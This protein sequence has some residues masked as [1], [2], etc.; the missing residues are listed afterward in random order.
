MYKL[1]LNMI[2]KNE[3]SIIAHTL[4][5]V[6][7][8]IPQIDYYVISDTGSTDDTV[9]VIKSFFKK[10][11]IKGEIYIDEWKDFGHNRS[12]ALE[13]AFKKSHYLIVFD[14]DDEI[15]GT[16]PVLDYQRLEFDGYLLTFGPHVRYERMLII[17]N[18]YRWCYKG[19]LHEYIVCEDKPDLKQ[20]SVQGDYYIVSGKHGHRSQ[21]PHKYKKDAILLEKA[22]EEAKSKND[23]LYNRY[24]FYCAQSYFDANDK[25]S[26]IQWYKKVCTHDGWIQEKYYA[27]YRLYHCLRE[28]RREEEG[29][30]YLIKS[31]MYD[32]QRYDCLYELIRYY[33]GNGMESIAWTFYRA[34]QEEFE[35]GHEM[36]PAQKL[37]V[38]GWY[39]K[40]GLPYY[41]IIVSVNTHHY[42]TAIKMF[43]LIFSKK[44]PEHNDFY[45][46]HLLM[47]VNC[48]LSHFPSVEQKDAFLSKLREYI[49]FLESIQYPIEKHESIYKNYLEIK[50]SRPT[51]IYTKEECF[52]STHILIYVGNSYH[53]W[54]Y[55]TYIETGTGG[56]ETA[57]IL[58]ALHFPKSYQVCIVGNVKEET[59]QNITFRHHDHASDWIQST[60][61]KLIIV[62]R[63]LQFF[64]RFRYSTFYVVAWAH[65]TCFHDDHLLAHYH[66]S[67]DTFVML[68]TWHQKHLQGRYPNEISESKC[69]IIFNGITLQPKIKMMS[70]KVKDRFIYSSCMERGLKKIIELWPAILEWKPNAQLIICTYQHNIDHSIIEQIKSY[71]SS[72]FFKG[73]MN[74][75]QLYQLMETCEYWFYPSHWPETS[76]ITAMEMMA[77]GILCCYYPYAGLADTIA[78]DCG[79]PLEEGKE[80][81]MMMEVTDSRRD[82]I[83]QQA[84][85]HVETFHWS[86][87]ISNWNSFLEESLYLILIPPTFY[88]KNI[89]DYMDSLS[90]RYRIFYT[91]DM[92]RARRIRPSKVFFLNEIFDRELYNYYRT[93][94]VTQPIEINLLNTEPL[95]IPCRLQT[96]LRD[97][98]HV[99]YVYDYSESNCTILAEQQIHQTVYF[100]YLV[101]DTET[102]FLKTLRQETAIEYD[103]GILISLNHVE[104]R[105]RVIDS[106]QQQGFSILVIRDQWKE[107]RDRQLSKCRYILNIHGFFEQTNMIFEQIRCDRLL[108][109]GFSILSEECVHIT[110][111]QSS[112]PNLHFL[113]YQDFFDASVLRKWLS[114]SE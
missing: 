70:F 7:H 53:P 29:I 62:S 91:Q 12:K 65:D 40:F 69:K 67:I 109:A 103:F 17:N 6:L 114:L 104:R 55:S 78:I 79:V 50:E 8:K 113:P 75:S 11:K 2:V 32:T 37:F 3:S 93:L 47:N 27:C 43:Q 5:N 36:T 34:I 90:T 88:L 21:D 74:K 26:A 24:C 15:C 13:Y 112:I 58:L 57:A 72:V 73:S 28:L 110:Q 23:S 100:P 81:S 59:I 66:T 20:A 16:F 22:Y 39:E 4:E 35:K 106:I 44:Y 108:S 48:V 56:S 51:T 10:K 68:T 95:N 71:S 96:V 64:R 46:S 49:S 61:F 101:Y 14:A 45:L 9:S 85:K 86:R 92:E 60:K 97:V 25:E 98:V 107:N 31:M 111:T 52:D 83:I 77:H 19:V 42:E 84:F 41:M 82:M 63:Y 94:S 102:Q 80:I 87:I 89:V 76:C 54:N 105:H 33:C 18:Q 1:C 38:N 99:S 30:F